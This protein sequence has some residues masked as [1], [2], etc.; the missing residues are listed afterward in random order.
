MKR[1]VLSL[2]FG[3]AI[4]LNGCSSML[5]APDANR[6][7]DPK[8]L[9]IDYEDITISSFAGPDSHV[10]PRT[11]HA[12]YFKQNKFSSPKGFILFFHGNG[13]N[14]SSHFV[15]LAW[16]IEKGYDYCIFDYQGYAGSEGKPSQENTVND[17]ISALKWFFNKAKDPRYQKTPLL[18]F[19]QS[20][21]GAVALRSLEEYPSQE[22]MKIPSS[23]KWVV[24]DSTFLSYRQ[25]AKSVLSQHW[26]T[27][28]LQPLGSLLVSDE[29]APKSKLN[30]L[31]A[32]N[33]L[34]LHG[35]QDQIIDVSLGRQLFEQMPEPKYW[36][37]LPG[38]RHIEGFF[39]Q[40]GF[41]RQPFLKLIESVDEASSMKQ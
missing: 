30:Q 8:D 22:K 33:Y 35:D 19:A 24:L 28:L 14:R 16:M 26:L 31:P 32:T 29:W 34:V 40:D 37:L 11:L 36:M 21:G 41:Y 17:G 6:Y 10:E 1:V 39:I 3:F 18:V 25:A 12:W 9:K 2:V 38:A 15:E 20:L 4:L 13:Q 7:G 23:L 27:Y 5:Y